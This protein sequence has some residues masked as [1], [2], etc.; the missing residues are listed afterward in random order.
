MWIVDWFSLANTPH[1]SPGHARR[2]STSFSTSDRTRH[3]SVEQ[4][5]TRPSRFVTIQP[6]LKK[7][8]T[9]QYLEQHTALVR[10]LQFSPDGKY[11]A[12]ASWDRTAIIWNVGDPC[13]PHKTLA[14]PTGFVGQVAW[15]PSGSHLLTRVSK[16]I[17]IWTDVR[18]YT[19]PILLCAHTLYLI[20]FHSSLLGRCLY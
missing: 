11:L 12:T 4:I 5:A 19:L 16:Q 17:K 1:E 6:A 14:H 15:S 7:L 18:C 9:T 20:I 8:T 2:Q 13:T 3:D 10:H